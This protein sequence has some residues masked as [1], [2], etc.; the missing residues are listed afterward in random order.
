MQLTFILEAKIHI[1]YTRETH[2][3]RGGIYHFIR[4]MFDAFIKVLD[5]E[6]VKV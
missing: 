2:Q 3:I 4:C 6:G 5:C 1:S